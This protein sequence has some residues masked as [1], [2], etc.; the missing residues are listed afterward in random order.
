MKTDK[1][2]GFDFN[3]DGWS[4]T[5]ENRNDAVA[6]FGRDFRSDLKSMLKGTDWEVY[7]LTTNYFYI[8]G[9]LRNE[10]EN[11]WAYVCCSD[12]RFFKD[13]WHDSLLI[14]SARDNKDYTGGQNR[15]CA[16]ADIPATLDK[17][18]TLWYN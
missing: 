10:K 12:V 4:E 1:W 6:Q 5:H 14:R 7:G 16:F 13:E 15:F 11:K 8:S 17:K 9:F 3:R 2:V 18:H